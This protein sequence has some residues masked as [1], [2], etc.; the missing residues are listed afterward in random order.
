MKDKIE[1][2][3][4]GHCKITDDLGNVLL[5][6]H[7]AVHPQNLCRVFARS[8]SNEFNYFIERIAFGNGGTTIN[9]AYVITYNPP[10]DGQPPDV[11]TW[12]SRIYHEVFSKIIDATGWPP[13]P[14]STAVNPNLG[15]DPGSADLNTGVRIGGGSVP[16]ADP[17]A[18]PHVSGP[19][20]RSLELGLTS[21]VIVTAVLNAQEPVA[22]T[23]PTSVS[24]LSA[25]DFIFD[26]IGLYTTGEQAIP[27][28]G[29][30]NI[31]VGTHVSTDNSGLAA[32][33]WYSFNVAA[34]SG[35]PTTVS[36]TTPAAGT[37][38]S[39][40]IT[41]GD[42]C[43]AINAGSTTW[44]P[45]WG[46]GNPLPGNS[47]IAITDLSGGTYSTITGKNTFG[48]L[49][50]QSGASGTASTISITPGGS[51]LK[52]GTTSADAADFISSLNS[53]IGGIIQT[54][55]NGQNA[56]IQNAVLSPST[57]RERLLTH[58]VFSPVLKAAGRTL[59]VV[60]TITISVARSTVSN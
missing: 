49:T 1:A 57:E 39:G 28:N 59:T 53:P 32:T 15:V 34:N 31:N 43:Q 24:T 30:Q 48:Y 33:T 9:S 20:V 38:V 37:G 60:Y 52:N 3:V 14:G 6:K 55:T 2:T 54:P 44:N 25:Q 40:A 46:G 5:D 8:L 7:N 12:D 23:N 19:G 47:T 16:S 10:N 51:G 11:G 29:Y 13:T 42:I 41:F 22:Q 35:P 4:T 58:L 21:Q 45:T 26:E 18:I 36:F 17:T 56:G 27:T 50:I